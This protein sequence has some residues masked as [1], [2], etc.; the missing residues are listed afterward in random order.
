ML[1]SAFLR[2][3]VS[4][5]NRPGRR[6]EEDGKTPVRDKRDRPVTY[7]FYGDLHLS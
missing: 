1:C 6:K 5:R 4:L 3:I 7:V 2:L